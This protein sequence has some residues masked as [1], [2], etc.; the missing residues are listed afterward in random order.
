M[1]ERK[2]CVCEG[3]I[4]SEREQKGVC[5][6]VTERERER[7]KERKRLTF[8]VLFSGRACLGGE[9]SGLSVVSG[10][11]WVDGTAPL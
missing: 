2:V 10:Q 5:V 4:S 7:E 9:R 11:C 3:E 1:P 6:C 8:H